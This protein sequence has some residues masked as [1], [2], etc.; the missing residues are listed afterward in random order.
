ML[1]G[2][3]N[4]LGEQLL[5]SHKNLNYQHGDCVVGLGESKRKLERSEDMDEIIR[6]E[7]PSERARRRDFDPKKSDRRTFMVRKP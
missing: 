2:C 1:L 6:L 7:N 3:Q 5:L 4:C